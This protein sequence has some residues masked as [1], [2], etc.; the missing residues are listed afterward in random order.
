MGVIGAKVFQ[1]V[2]RQLLKKYHKIR[3]PRLSRKWNDSL[4]NATYKTSRAAVEAGLSRAVP[5]RFGTS[6]RLR[7]WCLTTD[8]TTRVQCPRGAK[9]FSSI[10]CV[11][12]GSGAHPT[13]YTGRTG[14]T[15]PGVKARSG[16]DADPSAPI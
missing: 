4:S 14:G 10:F 5:L 6:C 13:S 8:W 11:Q 2:V 16:C 1:F 9:D 7:V 12:A 15:F 3:T